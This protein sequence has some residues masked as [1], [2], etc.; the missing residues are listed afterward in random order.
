MKH[1]DGDGDAVLGVVK[2]KTKRFT[3]LADILI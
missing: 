3:L 2:H 1:G